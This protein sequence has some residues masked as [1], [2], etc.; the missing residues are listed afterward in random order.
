M[1]A[2][3]NNDLFQIARSHDIYFVLGMWA[4]LSPRLSRGERIDLIDIEKVE[5]NGAAKENIVAGKQTGER[6]T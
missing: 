1:V 6:V 2:L 5:S 3:N 4:L